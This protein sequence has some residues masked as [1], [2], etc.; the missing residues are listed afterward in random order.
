MCDLSF[1]FFSFVHFRLVVPDCFTL[2]SLQILRRYH[3]LELVGL[4]FPPIL[5]KSQLYYNCVSRTQIDREL[6]LDFVSKRQI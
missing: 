3:E 1:F 2:V 4:N 5:L 6:V